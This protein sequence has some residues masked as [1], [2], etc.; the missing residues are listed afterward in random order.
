MEALQQ[1][2]KETP[3]ESDALHQDYRSHKKPVD[4]IPESS[5]ADNGLAQHH[6]SGE[7][8]YLRRSATLT[9]GANSDSY[10]AEGQRQTTCRNYFILLKQ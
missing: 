3:S 5:K 1:A 4:G 8:D 7:N 2:S 10:A 9:Q 6:V